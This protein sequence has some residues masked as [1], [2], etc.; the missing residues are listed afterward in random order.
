MTTYVALLYS[1]GIKDNDRLIMAEW[2][3]VAEALGFGDPRTCLATGN[4]V[5]EST[6]RSVGQIETLLED[7]H[8]K[9]FGRRVD[10]IVR[11]AAAW[12]KIL[13]ANPFPL[14][15]KKDPSHVLVRVNRKPAP[16]NA[17]SSLTPYMLAGERLGIGTS[18]N[19]NT[20]R[21][22]GA[23]MGVPFESAAP[24]VSASSR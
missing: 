24:K 8:A 9:A 10:I 14:E 18:R 13:A 23:L 22:I 1:I 12:R 7:A 2:R 20:V 6:L 21:Q 19:W 3:A 16:M 15:S 4:L 11:G 17:Q 5:F